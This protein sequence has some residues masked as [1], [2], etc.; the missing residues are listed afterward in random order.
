MKKEIITQRDPKSPVSEVFRTLRTNIQFMNSNKNL[1][2]LLVTSTLP[3]EGKSWVSANL[4]VTFAQAGKRV[5]LVDADMRKGRQFSLFSVPPTPGLSN[6]LSNMDSDG[7]KLDM[8]IIH[9]IRQTE[10][11]NLYL[12]PAGNVPPNPSELLVSDRM[13]NL[14]DKL[15]EICDVVIFDGTPSLLVTDAVIISRIVDSSVIVVSQKETKMDNLLKVKKDIE[16]VGGKIAGVVINKMQVSQNEYSDRYYYGKNTK[17]TRSDTILPHAKKEP[18][19][20]KD[21]IQKN[22]EKDNNLNLTNLTADELLKFLDKQKT[23]K[24]EEND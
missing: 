18:S 8:D 22:T 11:P 24:G 23:N 16:N 12:M 6:Y 10:V 4:A 20:N 1:R 7:R 17:S 3:S 9:F 2:S 14:T 15:H 13:M 19:E 5:I 21:N